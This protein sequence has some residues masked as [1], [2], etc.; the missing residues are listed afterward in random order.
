MSAQSDQS[1]S[2]RLAAA[3]E[4]AIEAMRGMDFQIDQEFG[5]GPYQ[6]DESII[7]AQAA[8]DEYRRKRAF[9]EERA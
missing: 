6:E 5:T 4:S 9:D 7:A 2:A 1:A 3:L 8:L